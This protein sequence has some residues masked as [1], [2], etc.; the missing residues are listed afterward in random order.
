MGNGIWEVCVCGSVH[1]W[2]RGLYDMCELG[3]GM[4]ECVCARVMCI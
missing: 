2:I 3:L 1:V 4:C